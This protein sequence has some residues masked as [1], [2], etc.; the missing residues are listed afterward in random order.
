M[1]V[2]QGKE[3]PADIVNIRQEPATM[4]RM[5]I[6]KNTNPSRSES[7]RDFIKRAAAIGV[8]APFIVRSSA[9]G[10]AGNVAPSNRIA[11]GVIGCGEHGANWNIPR[12]FQCPEAQL[13]AIC[14]VDADRLK[15]TKRKVDAYYGKKIGKGYVGCDP[16]D[17]FR[18]L[19]MRKDI[20]AVANCTPD[21]WHVIPAIM[22]AK[23]GKD[24]L[25][26]KPLTLTID[27]GKQLCK[28]VAEHKRVFQTASENRSI[29]TYI[30]IC[31]LV[32]N[33][34]IGKLQHIKVGLPGGNDSRGVN[35]ELRQPAPV[36]DG[37]NYDMWQGQAPLAPYAPAR[38]HGSFRWNYAYSGGR[39]T[40]WGAHLIDLAQ[41]GNGT[42]DTGPVEV[43]GK[44]EF[45]PPGDFFNTAYAFDVNYK[46]A[47]G[48][49]LNVS[50]GDPSIR[51]EGTDGWIG[52]DGWRAPLK[53]SNDKILKSEIEPDEI[54]L[55]RP[56]KVIAH[57]APGSGEYFDFFDC[58]KTRKP[59]YAPAEVGHR[60]ISVAHIGNIS[61]RLG[62][63][64]QWNPDDQQ[65][66]NDDE[67]NAMLARKQREPWTIANT[68]EWIAERA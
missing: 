16:H 63:K 26:E 15:A 59:C 32:R 11:I 38:C 49:T 17:D 22:A 45:P 61:M 51:F 62:K 42:Q 19:I 55:H 14:D 35:Y 52:F 34:R 4:A 56:K 25:C 13:I 7:R 68:D 66:V 21:H 57:N 33:G 5:K 2:R 48:V 40:D 41:W 65:F 24:V 8:A 46:Y 50:S 54:H 20:D 43:H 28:T 58:I 60:T 53:A 30:R 1:Y 44:G 29:D 37:F 39:L 47:N 31:E 3:L 18:D 9:L 64:L 27:E 23:A 36:P 67:A 6:D 10:L 12:I